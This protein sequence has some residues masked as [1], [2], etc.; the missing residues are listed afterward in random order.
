MPD[1]VFHIP[2]PSGSIGVVIKDSTGATVYSATHGNTP[3]TVALAAGSYILYSTYGFAQNGW[4]FTVE[5]CE[6]P[7]LYSV[8]AEMGTTPIFYGY[9]RF[10]FDM[11]GG[12]SCPFKIGGSVSTGAGFALIINSLAD[13]TPIGGGIYRRSLWIGGTATSFTYGVTLIDA[14]GTICVPATTFAIS[15]ESPVYTVTARRDG[16]DC[17]IDIE[18]TSKGCGSVDVNFTETIGPGADVGTYSI[19]IPDTLPHT[20]AHLLSPNATCGDVV[21][22]VSVMDCC[23]AVTLHTLNFGEAACVGPIPTNIALRKTGSDYFIDL[24]F[25]DC[26][27]DCHT[28]LLYGSQIGPWSSGLGV[29]IPF[30]SSTVPCGGGFPYTYSLQI[31]PNTTPIDGFIRYAV[32]YQ[33]CC[34]QVSNSTESIAV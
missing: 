34:C 30:T 31:Y 21:Y 25:A 23:D 19:A 2:A 20:D 27:V 33:N 16:D 26:G 12:F 15:C 10:D 17:Y 1:K 3:F 7:V 8:T 22:N 29:P 18:F 11:S 24:T 14:T 13:L 9:A 4:C 28:F 5:D 32:T 6:C